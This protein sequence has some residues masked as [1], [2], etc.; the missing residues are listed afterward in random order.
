MED[1]KL[2]GANICSSMPLN[3]WMGLARDG[4]GVARDGV[5]LSLIFY[6]KI[7]VI[8]RGMY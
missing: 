1:K 2:H 4:M 5:E 6:T 7:S 3:G 8:F